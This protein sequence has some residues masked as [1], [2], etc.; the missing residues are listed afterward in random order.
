MSIAVAPHARYMIVCDE[1]LPD[2]QLAHYYVTFKLLDCR[3]PSPGVYV[4]EFRFDDAVI[5][6]QFV[7]GEVNR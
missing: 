3:F 2:P 5:C 7:D 4:V 1:V 6:E